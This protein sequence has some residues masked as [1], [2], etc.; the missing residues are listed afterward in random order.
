MKSERR[1]TEA[2]ADANGDVMS[3]VTASD[4]WKDVIDGQNEFVKASSAKS[5]PDMPSWVVAEA[6]EVSRT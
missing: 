6:E 2:D 5:G 4:T 1:S 3:G